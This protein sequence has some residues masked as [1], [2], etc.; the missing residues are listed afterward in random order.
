MWSKRRVI[1]R[2]SDSE[3]WLWMKQTGIDSENVTCQSIGESSGADKRSEQSRMLKGVVWGLTL[4]EWTDG[5]V[6]KE[7]D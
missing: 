5:W 4:C 3:E 2:S 6:W 7:K 1:G